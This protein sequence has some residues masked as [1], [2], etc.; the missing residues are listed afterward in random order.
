MYYVLPL[1]SVPH[2]KTDNT[3]GEKNCR[4]NRQRQKRCTIKCEDSRYRGK[5]VV[6]HVVRHCSKPVC[7][8]ECYRSHQEE[9]L[10]IIQGE[11]KCLDAQ[12]AKDQPMSAHKIKVRYI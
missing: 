9:G 3:S 11:P 7:S 2:Y 4:G 6:V 12:S 10:C 8:V 1:T 5:R